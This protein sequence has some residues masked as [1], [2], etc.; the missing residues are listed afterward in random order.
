TSTAA[1][2]TVN[3]ATRDA[4]S[5]GVW[6]WISALA[7]QADEKI[8]VSS[9]YW[10]DNYGDVGNGL[11][12]YTADGTLDAVLIPPGDAGGVTALALQPDGKILTAP[13]RRLNADGTLDESFKAIPEPDGYISSLMVQQDGK[14]L[15]GGCFENLGGEAHANIGRLNPDGTMDHSFTAVVLGCVY[16]L[17]LQPDGRILVGGMFNSVNGQVRNNL[18]RLNPDGSLDAPFVPEFAG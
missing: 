15:V 10:E 3:L 17:A 13:F 8:L 7:I 1:L 14:I 5:L 2:L 9:F 16:A 11:K 4:F 6:G 18:A 12:R